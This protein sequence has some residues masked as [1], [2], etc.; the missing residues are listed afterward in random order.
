LPDPP[1]GQARHEPAGISFAV[2]V[3]NELVPSDRAMSLVDL[4]GRRGFTTMDVDDLDRFVP[5]DAACVPG[6]SAYI[7]ADVDTGRETLDVPPD[8][9]IET[10]L[11]KQRS[12]LTIDEGVALVT[13]FPE[14]LRTTNCFSMLGSRCGDRRVTAMWI[15]GGRPRLGWCWAGAPHTWLGSASCRARVGA[16]PR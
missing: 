6:G 13:H 10:V 16:P 12:P 5:I 7:V 14:S 1:A 3:K 4:R 15:C 8:Q 11:R 9:A 2:V